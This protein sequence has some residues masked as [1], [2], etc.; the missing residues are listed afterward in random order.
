M[1]LFPHS[2]HYTFISTPKRRSVLIN[3]V[4][5][6]LLKYLSRILTDVA[7]SGT[8]VYPYACYWFPIPSHL[9]PNTFTLT[10]VL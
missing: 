7:T 1:G 10:P 6:I 9:Y 3:S 5:D 4:G 8:L 2:Y